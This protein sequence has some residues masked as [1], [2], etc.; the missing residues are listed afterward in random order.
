MKDEDG[1]DAKGTASTL[2]EQKTRRSTLLGDLH[3]KKT[4]LYSDHDSVCAIA[5]VQFGENT[6]Q[7]ILHGVLRDVQIG[8]NNLVGVTICHASEHIEFTGRNRIIPC[9]FGDL[10]GDL[11]GNAFMTVVNKTNRLD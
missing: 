7:M 5:R 1:S 8:S 10:L 4:A 11:G 3:I 2:K 9:M 6:F